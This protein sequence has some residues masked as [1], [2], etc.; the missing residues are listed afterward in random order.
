[1]VGEPVTKGSVAFL[2]DASTNK[3]EVYDA[4]HQT[5]EATAGN[6]IDGIMNRDIIACPEKFCGQCS[7]TLRRHTQPQ[8]SCGV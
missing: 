3:V 8:Q 7:Q 6:F 1:M 5:A 2:E 4:A